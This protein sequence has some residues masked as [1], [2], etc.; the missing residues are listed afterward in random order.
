MK[1]FIFAF[2]LTIFAS[3]I[4]EKPV[5]AYQPNLEDVQKMLTCAD[6]EA[7]RERT[8]DRTTYTNYITGLGFPSTISVR[9]VTLYPNYVTGRDKCILVYGSAGNVETIMPNEQ[10]RYN[11]EDRYLGFSPTRIPSGSLYEDWVYYPVPNPNYVDYCP[12]GCSDYVNTRPF[13]KNPARA[14]V[15]G[16]IVVYDYNTPARDITNSTNHPCGYIPTV[17]QW[18]VDGVS[19]IPSNNVVVPS[20]GASDAEWISMV[21]HAID[22][23][24]SRSAMI[25]NYHGDF[26]K[27]NTRLNKVLNGNGVY[28]HASVV[29]RPGD[30]TFGIFTLY[31]YSTNSQRWWYR[32][33][34][35]PPEKCFLICEGDASVGL[36]FDETK[37]WTTTQRLTGS[38]TVKNELPQKIFIPCSAVGANGSAKCQDPSNVAGKV[39][40]K[41]KPTGSTTYSQ[42]VFDK[43]IQ[44]YKCMDGTECKRVPW[45][46][47]GSGISSTSA[48]SF[49]TIDLR[50][51]N[52]VLPVGNYQI[53][54]SIPLYNQETDPNNNKVCENFVVISMQDAKVKISGPET[55]ISEEP[56]THEIRISNDMDARITGNL[57]IKIEKNSGGS[58]VQKDN[59]NKGYISIPVDGYVDV[60]VIDE[61]LRYTVG[62]YR[63]KASITRHAGESDAAVALTSSNNYDEQEFKVLPFVP[64]N[65]QCK[66]LEV[67]YTKIISGDKNITKI[68]I[69]QLP[70]F[71]STEIEGGQGTFFYIGYRLFPLP[72]PA[73]EVTNLDAKGL[74]Q[75]YQMGEPT[76]KL[77]SCNFNI[78]NDTKCEIIDTFL[79]YPT[80]NTNRANLRGPYKAG[81]H[82]FYHYMYRGRWFP[83]EVKFNFDVTDPSNGTIDASGEVVF[84]VHSSCYRTDV[85][86]LKEECRQLDFY[87]PANSSMPG[88]LTVD[89][90]GADG[91]TQIK[92][93]SDDEKLQF[94]NPGIHKFNLRVTEDQI[95]RYQ[96]DEGAEWQGKTGVGHDASANPRPD[97]GTISAGT[98][99]VKTHTT[100]NGP[101]GSRNWDIRDDYKNHCYDDE[102]AFGSTESNQC[103]HDHDKEFHYWIFDWSD[104]RDF[105]RFR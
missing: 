45:G 26:Y 37:T 20:P 61:D 21:N 100:S 52:I 2:F 93:P 92:K 83:E 102:D 3:Y 35:I 30:Y 78:T 49:R 64:D 6:L 59:I 5:K 12:S 87:V 75:E 103:F 28:N 36:N 68:C 25:S 86:D 60:D 63:I 56:I 96:F 101:G 38:I 24:Q 33:F 17:V 88:T 23:F 76:T 85:L 67:D 98:G 70:K 57:N 10:D 62:Q 74:F 34:M 97:G 105:G 91:R 19:C 31:F 73:Y 29:V 54:A 69:G 55:L 84:K 66:E 53:C 43:E 46:T 22:P 104:V 90:T 27:R 14:R 47:S 51:E 65:A 8:K 9:G 94:K 4:I 77:G 32:T 7:K 16:G 11:G 71:P 82:S 39:T 48:S 79:Y 15:P 81:P 89:T 58:W 50:G 72:L 80:D 40:V 99:P 41:K 13:A 44:R 18:T 1:I 95:Y 42:T